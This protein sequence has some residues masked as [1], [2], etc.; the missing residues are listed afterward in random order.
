MACNACFT[1][2]EVGLHSRFNDCFPN[3]PDMPSKF[4]IVICGAG[5]AG[6]CAGIALGKQG[7][8]I[9]ILE[10]AD[11]LSPAGAGIH[12][13]PNATLLLKEWGLLE[14]LQEKAVVPAGF[15]FRRYADSSI[16]ARS[17]FTSDRSSSSTP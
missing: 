6:L 14:R 12:I 16:L 9:I 11:A 7:H 5:I 13:P 2:D 17:K 1:D 10:R 4:K 15:V 8:D 3:F